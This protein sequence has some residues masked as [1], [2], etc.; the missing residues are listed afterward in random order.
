VRTPQRL[1]IA[2][3]S[4]SLVSIPAIQA[5]AAVK[6]GAKCTKVGQVKKSQGKTYRCTKAGKKIVW[7]KQSTASPNASTQENATALKAFGI[8]NSSGEVQSKVKVTFELGENVAQ[9]IKSEV[10]LYTERAARI[11]SRFVDSPK[12]I[13]VHVYSE[14]DMAKYSDNILFA[15]EEL[16]PW[17]DWFAKDANLR[18]SAYGH[19]GHNY[20]SVCKISQPTV[21]TGVTG[22][23]GVLYPSRSSLK[24]LN[25]MNR[26][27]APH[28]MFHVIQDYYLYGAEGS[29]YIPQ[30]SL[31]SAMPPVFREGGGVFF[32]FARGYETFKE[33][34][35]GF[36]SVMDWMKKDYAKD[37]YSL[38]TTEDVE[39]L[40][41]RLENLDR[42]SRTEYAVGAALHEWLIANYGLEKYINLTQSHSHKLKFSDVFASVYG[43]S[44]SDLYKQAASHVLQRI[45]SKL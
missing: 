41:V 30:S 13:I 15:H 38:R 1:L 45:N 2:L 14:K 18:D 12:E 9:D 28:E 21:C 6:A 11:Y 24:F 23:A 36:A 8:V 10:V 43:M 4:I 33:Y 25:Y 16:K 7:K 20:R 40:L 37:I 17:L 39:R 32:A 19:P 26:S 44:L 42:S 29:F 22:Q 27:V 34:E 35:L 5:N 3:L 31:D